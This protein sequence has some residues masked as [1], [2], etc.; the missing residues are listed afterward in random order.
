MY[1]VGG[2]VRD[3]VLGIPCKKD[4]DFVVLGSGLL[5]AKAFDEYMK[6][7]GTLIEFND[8][9]TARYVLNDLEIEFAG[10]RSEA[11]D[12]QSRK[13]RVKPASLEEDL[14][15]RDFTANAMARKVIA[16]GLSKTI[17]DPY[18]GLSDL[19]KKMI[20]TPLDPDE[21]FSED[22]LRILRAAR[23]A[24]QLEFDIDKH[25]YDSLAK[26]KKRLA[27]V[28]AERVKN[29]F[30]RLLAAAKPSV[31]LWI[32]YESGVLGEFL[33]EVS[34]L[35]GVEEMKGYLHKDNLSHSFKVVDNIAEMS[36]KVLLRY[37]GLVHDIGKPDTKRFEEKRGWTFDMHD[38]LGKKMVRLIGKRLRMS[39]EEVDYACHLVRWHLYPIALMDKGVT[40]SP[41]RRLIVNLRE[42]LADLLILC[43]AD[44]TTGNQERLR[45]RLKNYDILEDRIKEV[46]DKDKLRAFQSPLRGEEIMKRCSLKPGP[47]VGKIKKAIEEAILNGRI[48]NEY[49]ASVEYFEKIKDEYLAEAETWE[50]V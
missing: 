25:T 9:D 14:S 22:P 33:P 16:S 49:Q 6:G 4:I 8:F 45:R 39:K 15:R 32:L 24:A 26:N 18:L 10:A 27:I 43:R 31:G 50:N 20:R 28:S 47:T 44:I 34:A 46:L 11:Y 42:D 19:N 3:T 38:H 30:F 23:F 12:H 21:T 35:Q 13:P 1:A 5:F 41:V 2:Y 36:D 29:E 17:V 40:D 7:Q 48:V 37:V